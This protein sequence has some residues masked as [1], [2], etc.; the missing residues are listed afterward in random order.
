MQVTRWL[1]N[2]GFRLKRG[3][4]GFGHHLLADSGAESVEVQKGA[5]TPRGRGPACCDVLPVG[6]GS[7]PHAE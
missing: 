6:T 3:G 7:C 5:G 4:E 1:R 2:A